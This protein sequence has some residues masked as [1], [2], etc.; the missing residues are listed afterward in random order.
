MFLK[1]LVLNLLLICIF[2]SNPNFAQPGSIT[3][4]DTI[5]YQI[6]DGFGA[7]QSDASINQSWWNQLFYDD[8]ECS[9]YRLD[10]TPKLVSPYSDLNCFSPWFMGSSV[11]SVFNFEDASN[12]NG[13][14]GNRVRTYT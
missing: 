3:I 2:C 7:H 4:S 1:K 13:P 8:L 5:K 14:E 11:K 9:I 10:L 6:I 12:P